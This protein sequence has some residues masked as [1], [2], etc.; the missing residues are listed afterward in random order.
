MNTIN[1]LLL[2]Q[3]TKSVTLYTKDT[4]LSVM[5]CQR[6]IQSSF[7]AWSGQRS[8]GGLGY[9]EGCP[10]QRSRQHFTDKFTNGRGSENSRKF[11][12]GGT[13]AF[14]APTPWD[15]PL[16]HVLLHCTMP[17]QRHIA[18]NAFQSFSCSISLAQF[19]SA[20]VR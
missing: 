3:Q 9:E 7:V 20:V 1:T 17:V 19:C 10:P 6:R 16:W 12:A 5:A 18:L 11:A 13:I 14:I 15:P 4:Q 2:V 8:R